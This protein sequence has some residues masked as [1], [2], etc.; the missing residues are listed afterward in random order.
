METEK[1]GEP[2]KHIAFTVPERLHKAAKMKAVEEGKNLRGIFIEVLEAVVK[3]G[4]K[5]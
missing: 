1:P 5:S 4:K 2:Q 3:K